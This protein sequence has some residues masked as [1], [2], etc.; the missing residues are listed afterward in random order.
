MCF[1]SVI[2]CKYICMDNWCGYNFYI[3]F[4]CLVNN[5]LYKYVECIYDMWKV[6]KF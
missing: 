4:M 6:I 5:D 1:I 3:C 2:M